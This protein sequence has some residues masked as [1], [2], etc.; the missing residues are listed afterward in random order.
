MSDKPVKSPESQQGVEFSSKERHI[1][2]ESQ[3]M[4]GHGI[5]AGWVE[6]LFKAAALHNIH[7]GNLHRIDNLSWP[8]YLQKIGLS[9]RTG[10]FYLQ[11]A[12]RMKQMCCKSLRAAG[13]KNPEWEFVFNQRLIK[14]TFGK[15]FEN[16]HRITIADLG[17]H[18]RNL[19]EFENYLDGKSELTD[20]DVVKL[21]APAK[22]EEAKDQEDA[23]TK[24]QDSLF[25]VHDKI[26]AAGYKW[27]K[28]TR[29]YENPDGTPMTPEQL[30]EFVDEETGLRI[31][32]SVESVIDA[33]EDQILSLIEEQ[34]IFLR[35]FS[36]VKQSPEIKK[37]IEASFKDLSFRLNQFNANALNILG[38]NN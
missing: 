20:K 34:S 18:A 35:G 19:Q 3:S 28:E 6:K 15:F 13:E 26:L 1:Y 33:A 12:G 30:G 36:A 32:T 8:E 14:D 27:N 21:L 31:F 9:D 11:I 22:S 37:K 23:S 17:H 7:E 5:Q 16:G 29:R 24:K 2:N 25:E 4:Y 10:R 38:E